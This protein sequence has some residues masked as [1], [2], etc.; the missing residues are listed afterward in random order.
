MNHSIVLC[1]QLY[2]TAYRWSNGLARAAGA[3]PDDAASAPILRGTC[4]AVASIPAMVIPR[5]MPSRQNEG[6]RIAS[7][8]EWMRPFEGVA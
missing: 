7:R 2:T 8:E 1:T 6:V 4:C 5:T 3:V